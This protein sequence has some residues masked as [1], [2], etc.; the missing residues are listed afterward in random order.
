M[1]YVMCYLCY[2]KKY[3]GNKYQNKKAQK[4]ASIRTIF[5]LFVVTCPKVCLMINNF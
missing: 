4:L 1:R 5:I 3:Y 2:K